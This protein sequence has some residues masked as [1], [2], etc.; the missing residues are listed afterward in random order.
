MQ[1]RSNNKTEIA[2]ADLHKGL[3]IIILHASRIPPHIGMVI[4]G[5]YHSLSI[6]GAEINVSSETLLKSIHQ[7]KI[8]AI[9][10]R[11]IKHPVFSTEYLNECFIH[12]LLQSPTITEGKTS[13][14]SPVKDFLQEFF[15][16]NPDKVEFVYHLIPWLKA[17]NQ[18]AEIISFNLPSSENEFQLPKYSKDELEEGIRQAYRDIKQLQNEI[19]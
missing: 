15:T 14:F 12:Q 8:P 18:I 17:N 1:S 6:K 16:L 4:E 9:A 7:R 5:N 2:F 11:L 10:Y 13:C 3:W 19:R